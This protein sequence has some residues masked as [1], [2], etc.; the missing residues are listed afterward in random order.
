MLRQT[1]E[2]ENLKELLYTFEQNV[3]QKDEVI[4]NLTEALSKQVNFL[5][6]YVIYEIWP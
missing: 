3:K 5:F 2:I 1:H 4:K 6:D